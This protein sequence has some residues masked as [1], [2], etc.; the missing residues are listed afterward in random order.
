MGTGLGISGVTEKI[1]IRIYLSF[2][3]YHSHTDK[4]SRKDQFYVSIPM[5]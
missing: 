1:N 4:K 5:Y 3:K 2:L